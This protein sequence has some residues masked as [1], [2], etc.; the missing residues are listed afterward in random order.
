MEGG[1][2]NMEKNISTPPTNDLLSAEDLIM[3]SYD[4]V[5]SYMATQREKYLSMH[6]AP[7][8]SSRGKEVISGGLPICPSRR[9]IEIIN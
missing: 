8:T 2:T 7:E 4:D 1:C 5:Q 6:T 3:M 9:A